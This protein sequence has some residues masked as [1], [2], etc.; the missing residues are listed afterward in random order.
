MSSGRPNPN[1]PLEAGFYTYRVPVTFDKQF[2]FAGDQIRQAEGDKEGNLDP[3]PEVL[4]ELESELREYLG[5][6]Y[7]VESLEASAD[8]DSLLGTASWPRIS[9][10]RWT[11]PSSVD[12][13]LSKPERSRKPA[14]AQPCVANTDIFRT[15]P[16][17]VIVIT[18]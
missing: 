17:P 14:A 18:V 4:R 3:T 2:T 8:F 13:R 7:A 12:V 5:Q 1:Q 6:N 9:R 15:P 11:R 16:Y 10:T